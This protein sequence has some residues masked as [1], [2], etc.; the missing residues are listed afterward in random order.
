MFTI[1]TAQSRVWEPAPTTLP[2]RQC[3]V[4]VISSQQRT[5][6]LAQVLPDGSLTLPIAQP[7]ASD[8]KLWDSDMDKMETYLRKVLGVRM[9]MSRYMW[10]KRQSRDKCNLWGKE[11]TDMKVILLDPLE[12]FICANERAR[13]VSLNSLWQLN[14]FELNK[15]AKLD[16]GNL[17]EDT[18]GYDKEVFSSAKPWFFLTS[19]MEIDA[20]VKGILCD[21]GMEIQSELEVEH[22]RRTSVVWSCK[23]GMEFID[24]SCTERRSEML[25]IKA[26]LP[27][28]REISRMVVADDIVKDIAPIVIAAHE[29]DCLVIHRDAGSMNDEEH[30]YRHLMDTLLKLHVGTMNELAKLKAAG[31]RVRDANWLISNVIWITYHPATNKLLESSMGGMLNVQYLR[32]EVENIIKACRKLSS[33]QM[34]NTLVN[35]DLHPENIGSLDL[36][37]DVYRFYSW[38]NAVITHP[39]VDPSSWRK[40]SVLKD[41]EEV[42]SAI[43]MYCRYWCTYLHDEDYEVVLDLAALLHSGVTVHKLLLEYELYGVGHEEFLTT[44]NEEIVGLSGQSAMIAQKYF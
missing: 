22:L 26:S 37:E 21:K 39:F 7:L 29:S 9:R 11:Y 28:T 18:M 36:G 5:H 19:L 10:K 4:L 34:P 8:V 1:S 42:K 27:L 35:R 2:N 3:F 12:E 16:L 25:Y 30:D 6:V 33:Y 40:L 17:I 14:W 43:E 32:S 24:D 38:E 13:W 23:V 41:S 31:V 15:C 44:L 20:W